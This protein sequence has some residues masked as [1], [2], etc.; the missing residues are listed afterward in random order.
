MPPANSCAP[1]LLRLH[2]ACDLMAGFGQRHRGKRERG[3]SVS[4]Y[5]LSSSENVPG[6]FHGP[7]AMRGMWAGM[8]SVGRGG[9]VREGSVEGEKKGVSR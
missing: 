4:V 8:V 5:G 3:G 6:A 9:G 7:E 1:L 2:I